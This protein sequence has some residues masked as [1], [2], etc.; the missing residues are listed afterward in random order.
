V[1]SSNNLVENNKF[2][3]AIVI[4]INCGNVTQ[5]DFK[6]VCNE[7]T[8]KCEINEK[9]T[10]LLSECE[11]ECKAKTLLSDLIVE[12]F[13]AD[14]TTLKIDEVANISIVE[15]NIG[16]GKAGDHYG[17]ITL[18]ENIKEVNLPSL[19]ANSTN[20]FNQITFK[21]NSVGTFK[22]FFAVDTKNNVNEDNEDNNMKELTIKCIKDPDQETD[23][24]QKEE[25][26]KEEERKEEERRKED[27]KDPPV[28]P[29]EK[30]PPGAEENPEDQFF[31]GKPFTFKS[32]KPDKVTNTKS[33]GISVS[34]FTLK[35]DD[36]YNCPLKRCGAGKCGGYIT[37]TVNKYG[38]Q[39]NISCAGD[40]CNN[41]AGNP[42][43]FYRESPHKVTVTH[44]EF[45]ANNKNTS[46]ITDCKIDMGDGKIYNCSFTGQELND[47]EE[48][49]E[50]IY[51]EH[52]YINNTNLPV[53]FCPKLILDDGKDKLETALLNGFCD[54][55]CAEG[56]ETRTGCVV[57]Y[58]ES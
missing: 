25:E 26:R 40:T 36:C 21:C 2:N 16:K 33:G 32:A 28:D 44:N 19:E 49:G 31:R 58:P 47:S 6:Y 15:K 18:G 34:M 14:K 30:N 38:Y 57:I 27:Q 51:I 29:G 9:G 56:S 39:A 46:K 8:F 12:K 7:T 3:N 50:N 23:E 41:S 11:K 13:E 54:G 17:N 45:N 1:D 4:P 42:L 5:K 20:T 35:P 48:N 24:K 43:S 10:M 53:E 52:T 22:M 55:Y 37:K